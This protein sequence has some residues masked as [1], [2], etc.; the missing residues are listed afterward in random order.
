MFTQ[1]CLGNRQTSIRGR[2][3]AP[4][5]AAVLLC[6]TLTVHRAQAEG[7]STN[8]CID[9]HANGQVARGQG[10]LLEA[11]NAFSICAAD[12]C[13]DLI[14][15]DCT[16]F[17]VAV[18]NT[19]PTVIVSA[20]NGAGR[21]VTQTFVRVDGG[22]EKLPVDGRALYLDPGSHAFTVVTPE[23][24]Q[25]SVTVV[26]REGEKY[27]R[28]AVTLPVEPETKAGDPPV[29]AG[30]RGVSPLVY[31][32]GGLGLLAAGSFTYFALDGRSKESALEEC[33]PTCSRSGVDS[34]RRSYLIGDISLGVAVA[35]LGLGTYFL[36]RPPS[37]N[38]TASQVAVRVATNPDLSAFRVVAT[39]AF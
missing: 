13:P 23:G 1:V 4:L 8:E 14:R 38:T 7:L 33:A 36:L 2:G 6:A 15:Q 18:E 39:T 10:R 24:K 32:F 21:E 17:G 25:A 35:S 37:S 5:R 34:M 27:R 30:K 19:L 3:K 11:K 12:S 20:Q 28:V 29:E 9:A 31:V 22:P 26:L 16:Q